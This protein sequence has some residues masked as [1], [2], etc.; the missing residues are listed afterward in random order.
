MPSSERHDRTLRVIAVA[1]I[2]AAFFGF[3]ATQV[4]DVDFWW[5]IASGKYIV[6]HRS[7]P[8]QDPFGVYDACGERCEVILKRYPI[9]QVLLY[10]V[11]E[12]GGARGIILFKAALLA[13]CLLIVYR[14]SLALGASSPAAVLALIL[15]GFAAVHFTGERPQLFSVLF[16][17]A[18]LSCLEGYR[19]TRKPWLLVCIPPIMAIWANTHGAVLL[20]AALL[21]LYGTGHT[22]ETLRGRKSGL[23]PDMRLLVALG[24]GV[25]CSLAGPAGIA[26]YVVFAREIFEGSMV[27]PRTS[28]Y[29]SPF[30]VWR[31]LGIFMP[32][33][34]MLLVLVPVAAERLFRR[35]EITH[36]LIALFLAVITFSAFRYV[37]FFVFLAS[38]FIAAGAGRFL[39][40]LQVHRRVPIA[41]IIISM[42]ALFYGTAT[43]RAFQSGIR[44]QKFP[45][46]AAD[47][48][49]SQ[50]LRGRAFT[51]LEWGGYLTWRLSPAVRVYID[52]RLLDAERLVPYT[53][54]LW[55]TPQGLAF[56]RQERFDLV[57]VPTGNMLTGEAYPLPQ[58]LL[59]DPEWRVLYRDDHS[60]LF[61]RKAGT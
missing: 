30:E 2:I 55:A 54:I 53:N 42:L 29:L 6:E 49:A 15:T 35:G 60:F 48:A 13:A 37:L 1:A 46:G 22:V 17:A 33:Y 7:L 47:L 39:P 23:R 20:G 11:Y 58:Y 31:K 50:G 19:K 34:W 5:H 43:G 9:G 26:Q 61:Q 8:D 12:T 14:R 44:E 57:I 56:F 4:T 24:I 38:P 27:I 3:Y 10:L 16:G 59:R 40:E 52:G 41:L 51:S 45:M 28:E 36:A 25:V 21:G 18:V 32:T